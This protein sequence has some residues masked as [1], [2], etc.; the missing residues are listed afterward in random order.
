[1]I[2]L[3][4]ISGC[5]AYCLLGGAV[6]RAIPSSMDLKALCIIMWPFAAPFVLGYVL[7]GRSKQAKL[8]KATVVS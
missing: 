6:F 5:S 2:A 1:M 4:V 7:A 8:P 3:C